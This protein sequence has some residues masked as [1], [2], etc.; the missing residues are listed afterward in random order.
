MRRTRG[1][2][3]LREL[4]VVMLD[5]KLGAL[6]PASVHGVRLRRLASEIGFHSSTWGHGHFNELWKFRLKLLAALVQRGVSLIMNDLDAIWIQDPHEEIFAHLP[7]N[8]DI[9]GQRASFPKD[10]GRKGHS[11]GK[12]GR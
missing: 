3:G 9:M 8:T 11:P 7:N 5:D 10:L 2:R 12:W 4:A 1:N 6:L